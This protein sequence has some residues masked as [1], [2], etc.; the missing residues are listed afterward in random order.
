MTRLQWSIKS[1]QLLVL[2]SPSCILT[3]S[4]WNILL[5][6]EAVVSKKS[7]YRPQWI[8]PH[9]WFCLIYWNTFSSKTETDVVCKV[10]VLQIE[11][12][13]CLKNRIWT[14]IMYDLS[15]F[16]NRRGTTKLLHLDVLLLAV[17]WIFWWFILSIDIWTG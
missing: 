5:N 10:V 3:A 13:P 14:C 1:H 7:K 16:C 11:K 9:Y 8:S 6:H 17:N 12:K 4:K 15:S 2:L